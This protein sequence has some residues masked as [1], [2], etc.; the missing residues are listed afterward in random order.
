MKKKCNVEGCKNTGY[1]FFAGFC[2]EHN[3]QRE[4][5]KEIFKNFDWSKFKL[6]KKRRK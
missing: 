3:P 2:S 5:L 4:V 1:G 6:I